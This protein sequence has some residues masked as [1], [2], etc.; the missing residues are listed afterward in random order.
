MAKPYVP[1]TKDSVIV[2]R[3]TY[4]Y[5][6]PPSYVLPKTITLTRTMMSRPRAGTT[7]IHG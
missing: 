6:F 3:A 2:V 7:V 1:N 4:V 5:T